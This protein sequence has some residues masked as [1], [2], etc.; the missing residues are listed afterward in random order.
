MTE[1]KLDKR[2]KKNVQG[3]IENFQFRVG[4]LNDG[5]HYQAKTGKRGMKGQDVLK[6][7]AGGPARQQTRKP[8]GTI[9]S[10][11]AAFSKFLGFNYLT[12]PFQLEHVGRGAGDRQLII[13]FVDIFLKGAF[14]RISNP[15]QR[16]QNL[17][18]AIVR[19]P[20][21]RGDYGHNSKLTKAIKGF[22]RLGIDTSQLFRGI[23][24]EAR[25]VKRV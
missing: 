13:Q 6:S 14:G 17:L 19:N 10:V 8:N 2:F 3:R 7:F 24:A 25:K 9:S 11:S 1:I 12:Q 20:I 15:N 22:D 23:T 21:L 16:L 4:I 5:P 18:Q